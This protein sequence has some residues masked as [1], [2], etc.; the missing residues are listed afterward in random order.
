LLYAFT[1]GLFKP[2]FA[3]C[4]YGE[5]C[6]EIPESCQLLQYVPR[7]QDYIT[8]AEPK[9]GT[10]AEVAGKVMPTRK[11]L[12]EA[13]RGD[14]V[15]AVEAA[16]GFLAVAQMLGL[17]S[18]RRPVGYWENLD[19]LDEVSASHS[20]CAFAHQFLQSADQALHSWLCD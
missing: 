9:K 4:G 2:H 5:C 8:H 6:P 18:R 15:R 20:R 17:R 3:Y 11:E 7:V 19:N 12:R 10:A 16:G 1:L 14:L 13:G